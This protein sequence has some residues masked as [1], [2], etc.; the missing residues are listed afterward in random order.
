MTKRSRSTEYRKN[1]MAKRTQ[2]KISRNFSM[3]EIFFFNLKAE[4]TRLH[5][6]IYCERGIKLHLKKPPS[7]LWFV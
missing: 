3:E 4:S 6:V 5:C 7:Y 2:P 1:K